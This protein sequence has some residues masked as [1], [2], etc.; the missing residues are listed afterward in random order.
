MT[1]LAAYFV[2]F[3]ALPIVDFLSFHAGVCLSRSFSPSNFSCCHLP[4]AA[5]ARSRVDALKKREVM[6]WQCCYATVRYG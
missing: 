6:I 3:V 5:C 1:H 4:V 2:V